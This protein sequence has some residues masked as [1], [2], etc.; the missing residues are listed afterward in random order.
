MN[1]KQKNTQNKR[2]RKRRLK[3]KV[4]WK[5]FAVAL[6]CYG[7]LASHQAPEEIRSYNSINLT[8]TLTVFADNSSNTKSTWNE[9]KQDVDDVTG[10]TADEYDELIMWICDHRSIEYVDC[11]FYEKGDI[12][13]QIEE[14]YEISG[15][16][17]LAIWT[18]ESGFGTSRMAR[19]RNNYG[20]IM[21]KSGYR[22][23]DSIND[24]MLHQGKLLRNVY[25]DKD[26]DTWKEIGGRYCPGNSKWASNVCGTLDTYAEE[27]ADIMSK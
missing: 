7:V 16:S 22:Y 8:D 5:I 11:P 25:V 2:R 13:V 19:N 27:L 20:G 6:V 4:L 26:Y 12:L 24:G 9:N 21:G 1:Q 23:F 18:W 15:L 14:D 3:T 17:C 10:A